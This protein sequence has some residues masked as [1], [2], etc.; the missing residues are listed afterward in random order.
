MAPP[1]PFEQY[2]TLEEYVKA[3]KDNYPETHITERNASF[4]L[5]SEI[6]FTDAEFKKL[7]M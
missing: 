3:I 1:N 2:N 5:S 7:F 4:E 6:L